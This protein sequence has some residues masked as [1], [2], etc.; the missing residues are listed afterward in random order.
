LAAKFKILGLAYVSNMAS[1][2]NDKPLSHEKV[3]AEG[4]KVS[5]NLTRIIKHMIP[6]I[7]GK[8]AL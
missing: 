4:K 6:F 7:A 3:L 1:G 5:E 8:G 2:I